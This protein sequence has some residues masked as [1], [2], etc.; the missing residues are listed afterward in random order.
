MLNEKTQAAARSASRFVSTAGRGPM[1]SLLTPWRVRAVANL[2]VCGKSSSEG[3]SALNFGA[4]V[5]RMRRWYVGHPR[6]VMKDQERPSGMR[7]AGRVRLP[8]KTIHYPYP[9]AWR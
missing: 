4:K 9:R 2:G 6:T 7:F 5:L 3:S 1:A 8:Q